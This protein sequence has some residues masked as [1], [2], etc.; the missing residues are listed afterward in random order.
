MKTLLSLLLLFTFSFSEEKPLQS[1][2]SVELQKYMGKWYEIARYE[3][4]FE[5]GCVGATAEYLLEEEK[6]LVI[7]RC[8][9]E[10]GQKTDEANGKAYAVEG[11]ENARL[12]VT[13]FWPFYGNYWIITLAEDYRY[14]I[15][16]EP[17][18]KYLWILARTKHLSENDKDTIIKALDK[19]GYDAS[20]LYWTKSDKIVF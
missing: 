15:V 8:Y 9:N 3:N 12:R 2:A 16:G 13:F 4:W 10:E 5:K 6:V 14:V 11:S 17:S 19:H 7:N 1:V 20:K 18:R